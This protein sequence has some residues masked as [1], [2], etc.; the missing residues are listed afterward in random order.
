MAHFSVPE[1]IWIPDGQAAA[2]ATK[3]QA[4]PYF[5]PQTNQWATG[6]STQ[7][8]NANAIGALFF[9]LRLN[10]WTKGVC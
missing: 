4:A 3:T 2:L 9:C 7:T 1:N 6:S 8:V 5:W 10:Q